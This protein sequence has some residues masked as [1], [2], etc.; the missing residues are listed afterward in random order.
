MSN[1]HEINKHKKITHI[2]RGLFGACVIAIMPSVAF[3]QTNKTTDNNEAA[4]ITNKNSNQVET[5]EQIDFTEPETLKKP[6]VRII[7]PRD[8]RHKSR[9]N[10]WASDLY[11]RPARLGSTSYKKPKLKSKNIRRKIKQ[12]RNTGIDARDLLVGANSN[13]DDYGLSLNTANTINSLGNAPGSE[14][15]ASLSDTLRG[16]LFDLPSFGANDTVFKLDLSGQL[17][18]DTKDEC[19]M[20]QVSDVQLDFATNITAGKTDGINLQLTPRGSVHVS[21][22]GKSALVGALVRIGDNLRKGSDMKSNTWYLFA[23]ADAEALTYTPNSM[24]R[25]TSGAFHLQDRIIIGD[26]QAGIGYKIG[27][28]DL[29]LT[30]F[31]RQARAENYSY[32]EDA[33]ALSVTWRR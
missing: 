21:D 29:S 6:R 31:R 3:A 30:Y 17:C 27:D 24:R 5:E 15:I 22:D 1:E 12:D 10:N 14:A 7:N 25:L 16:A 33:A 2:F 26:A 9:Y 4:I 28:A 23:G 8:L 18:L 32:D 13:I 20:R 19:Q 11:N